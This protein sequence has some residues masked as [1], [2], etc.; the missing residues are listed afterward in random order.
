MSEDISISQISHL[1]SKQLR[2]ADSCFKVTAKDI[3]WSYIKRTP[4]FLKQ[5]IKYGSGS[6]TSDEDFDNLAIELSSLEERF[7]SINKYVKSY[8]KSMSDILNS[9]EAAG[10]QFKNLFDPYQSLLREGGDKSADAVFEEEYRIWQDV[11]HYIEAIRNSK[12][13]IENE[14]KMLSDTAQVKTSEVLKI[15]KAIQKKVKE[16]SYALVDYDKVYNSHES[17]LLKQNSEGL[18]VKQSQ[19]LYSL[20][21]KSEEYYAKYDAI[22]SLLKK[23]L[24]FF[25]KLVD[26]VLDPLSIMVYYVQ[27]T[28]SFQ[29]FSN[30]KSV[31]DFFDLDTKFLDSFNFEEEIVHDFYTR[32]KSASDL[33]NQLSIINFRERYL[34]DLTSPYNFNATKYCQALFNFEGQEDSDLSFKRGDIIKVLKKENNWWTGEKDGKVGCFPGNYVNDYFL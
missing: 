23:E 33:V 18:T 9:C 3:E 8:E 17:L 1:L 12:L 31:I 10:E 7:S 26:L 25:F 2:V 22:N 30:L 20:E 19:Q 21:R 29:V 11:H 5:K 4:Q 14:I 16:R 13:A 15:V 6:Y 32:N 24:P 28:I 27:L 34:T